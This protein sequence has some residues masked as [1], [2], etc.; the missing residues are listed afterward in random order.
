MGQTVPHHRVEACEGDLS[1]RGEGER[2]LRWS[3]I[4]PPPFLSPLYTEC[5][6]VCPCLGMDKMSAFVRGVGGGVGWRRGGGVWRG[7]GGGV[8]RGG[9]DV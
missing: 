8:R 9:G 3:I 5:R 4:T 6:L 2:P 1:V 7:G